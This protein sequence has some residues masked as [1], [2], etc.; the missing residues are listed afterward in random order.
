MSMQTLS[1]CNLHP[2]LVPLTKPLQNSFKIHQNKTRNCYKRLTTT[3]VFAINKEEEEQS[4]TPTPS[5]AKPDSEETPP[6]ARNDQ[7]PSSGSSSEL[8]F[9]VYL[10]ASAITAIAAVTF[11]FI[12]VLC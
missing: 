5:W 8:P 12:C 11:L 9:F 2:S 6:W 10:L 7:Q 4:S 1:L 3:I